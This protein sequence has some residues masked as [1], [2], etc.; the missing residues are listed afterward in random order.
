M[1]FQRAMERGFREAIAWAKAQRS[2]KSIPTN[3]P[4][5][6]SE[7]SKI[8]SGWYVQDDKGNYRGKVNHRCLACG[9]RWL[10]RKK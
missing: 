4:N 5:C 2:T 7:R 3:C 6:W 10:W 8:V 9:T 1:I